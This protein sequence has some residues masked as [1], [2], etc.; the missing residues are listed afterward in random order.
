MPSLEAAPEEQGWGEAAV[1][2]ERAASVLPDGSGACQS[3]R[4]PL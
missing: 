4:Q 1:A 3:M 2:Q